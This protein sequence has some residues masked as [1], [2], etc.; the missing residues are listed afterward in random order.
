M[1]KQLC[2]VIE[3]KTFLTLARRPLM[4]GCVSLFF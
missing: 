2:R 4:L 1:S 3:N